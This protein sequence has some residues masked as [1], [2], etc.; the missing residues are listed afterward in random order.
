VYLEYFVT[1]VENDLR[2]Y[3]THMM[4]KCSG[5][6][7]YSKLWMVEWTKEHHYLNQAEQLACKEYRERTSMW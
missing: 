4:S 3:F 2:I 1:N 7:S 5:E 6:R